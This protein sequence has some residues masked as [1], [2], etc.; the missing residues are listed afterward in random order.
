MPPLR[1]G[2]TWAEAGG[3]MLLGPGASGVIAD[4]SPGT[5]RVRADWASGVRAD[6]ALVLSSG[7]VTFVDDH[8]SR[9]L[10]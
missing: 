9:V 7:S 8:G 3:S 6:G 4:G 5:S 2:W 10:H 1:G